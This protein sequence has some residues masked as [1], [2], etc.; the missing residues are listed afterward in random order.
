[1]EQV[2]GGKKS[3]TVRMGLGARAVSSS[4]FVNKDSCQNARQHLTDGIME[5]VYGGKMNLIHFW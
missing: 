2:S 4:G 3:K 5:L 1:M